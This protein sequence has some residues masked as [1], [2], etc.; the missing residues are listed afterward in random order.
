MEQ[1]GAITAGAAAAKPNTTMVRTW[2]TVLSRTAQIFAQTHPKTMIHLFDTYAYLNSILD[3]PADYG[4]KNITGFC[5]NYD[6]PDIATEYAK[7]G[8]LELKEYFWYN[9]GHITSHVHELLATGVRKFLET[10]E[11]GARFGG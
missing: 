6:A 1:P 5:K 9:G 3:H 8:C 2:N 7:Y 11:G 10:G 4:F